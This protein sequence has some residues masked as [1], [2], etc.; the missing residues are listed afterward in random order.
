MVRGTWYVQPASARH[1]GLGTW[2]PPPKQSQAPGSGPPS[3]IDVEGWFF[4]SAALLLVSG[5]A[6]LADPAP[7]SGAL[8]VAGMVS[9]RGVVYTLAMAEIATGAASLL[10][11]GAWGGWA[12]AALY[13]GFGV[14]VAFALRR[15]L[16]ISSCGCFGKADTPPS[17]VHVFL[18]LACLGG[19]VW[20]AL[21]SG[22]SLV[23]VLGDQ[24]MAG[25]LYLGFLVAGT[26]AAYLLLTALPVLL[27][28]QM[29]GHR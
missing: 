14:F 29:A 7:T 10:G 21:T 2:A 15:R 27:K 11:G 9:G 22:P 23:S 28:P 19:G 13:G 3:L 16:P 26:Y 6:K 24:P 17:L 20:A 8:R 1:L 25:L 18:N 4:L 5:G 12:M